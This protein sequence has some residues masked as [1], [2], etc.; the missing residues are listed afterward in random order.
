MSLPSCAINPISCTIL[1]QTDFEVQCMLRRYCKCAFKP[2][3]CQSMH[4]TTAILINFDAKC[5]SGR[6]L[7][8]IIGLLILGFLTGF[9]NV[10]PMMRYILYTICQKSFSLAMVAFVRCCSINK[11]KHHWTAVIHDCWVQF[12]WSTVVCFFSVRS[13]RTDFKSRNVS[14]SM[15]VS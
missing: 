1:K 12:L 8:I 14:V 6:F 11:E 13:G 2:A 15:K 10:K 9:P 7:S 5:Q 4:F 3:Y